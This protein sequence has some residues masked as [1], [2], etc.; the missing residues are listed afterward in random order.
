MTTIPYR[1][2][3]NEVSELKEMSSK[4]LLR[5]LLESEEYKSAIMRGFKQIDEATKT[6]LVHIYILISLQVY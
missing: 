6:F 5:K 3:R 1:V 2:L 4:G